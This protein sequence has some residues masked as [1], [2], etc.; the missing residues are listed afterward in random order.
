MSMADANP[1]L[2]L[3]IDLDKL[4]IGAG[5]A[6][7]SSPLQK[8][9]KQAPPGTQAALAWLP[10][11][12]LS[13]AQTLLS[14]QNGDLGAY[15]VVADADGNPLAST[16]VFV[17]QAT[18]GPE[19]VIRLA[20]DTTV[21]LAATPLFGTLLSGVRI[22]DL[23]VSYASTSFAPADIVLPAGAPTPPSIPSGLGLSTT[24]DANGSAQMFELPTP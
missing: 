1:T 6:G 3:T 10:D 23:A 16:F 21:D 15:V 19:A 5:I 4:E 11:L 13:E 9:I 20:L 12:S 22:T 14:I 18:D 8:L 17:K 24:V 7:L 2:I